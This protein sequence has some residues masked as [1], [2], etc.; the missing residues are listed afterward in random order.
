MFLRM[1]RNGM[2]ENPPATSRGH[3]RRLFRPG[4]ISL[5]VLFSLLPASYMLRSQQPNPGQPIP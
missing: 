1:K 4:A 3:V 5:F 2:N